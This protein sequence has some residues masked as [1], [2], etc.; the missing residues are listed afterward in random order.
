MHNHCAS[1]VDLHNNCA[2]V[3]LVSG[4]ISSARPKHREQSMTAQELQALQ[5]RLGMTNLELAETLGIHRNTVST[6]RREGVED[7]RSVYA[8]RYLEQSMTGKRAHFGKRSGGGLTITTTT[9]A[10]EDAWGTLREEWGYIGHPL[11]DDTEIVFWRH[12]DED[13]DE[14]FGHVLDG[15]GIWYVTL[16]E[17]EPLAAFEELL[18]LELEQL[19]Q[20]LENAENGV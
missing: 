8:L 15:D 1:G 20:A 2:N 6:W 13:E 12:G 16:D 14:W 11:E 3:S 19:R 4:N 18:G 5:E 17:P 10:L 9:A 7:I